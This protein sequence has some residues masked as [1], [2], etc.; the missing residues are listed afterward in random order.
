VSAPAPAAKPPPAPATAPKPATTRAPASDEPA[1]SQKAGAALESAQFAI[2]HSK[3]SVLATFIRSAPGTSLLSERG[4]VAADPDSNT[5][6][7]QDT[8]ESL[9]T[10]R[11]LVA[12]LDVPLKNF[13]IRTIIA[14]ADADLLRE[15]VASRSTGSGPPQVIILGANVP[16]VPLL[17]AARQAQRV[18]VISMPYLL[19][20]DRERASVEQTAN[21]PARRD[22]PSRTPQ[23]DVM[24]NLSLMPTARPDD[25]LSL[26]LDVTVSRKMMVPGKSMGGTTPPAMIPAIDSNQAKTQMLLKSGETAMVDI[27]SGALASMEAGSGRRLVAFVT[28]TQMPDPPGQPVTGSSRGTPTPPPPPPSAAPR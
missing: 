18:E 2:Q 1:D 15:L 10:I 16:I 8:A 25:Q 21:A 5:L 7:V 4:S 17:D 6:F 3:A 20:A 23:G 12:R 24:I 11:Q 26:D 27:M 28:A 22:E 9:A 19:V 13:A 14:V